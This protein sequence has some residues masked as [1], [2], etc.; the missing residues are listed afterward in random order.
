MSPAD[1]RTREHFAA[2]GSFRGEPGLLY[3]AT[4][5]RDWDIQLED[6]IAA[7]SPHPEIPPTDQIEGW[8][9][10]WL[11]CSRWAGTV[12][13]RPAYIYHAGRAGIG[14]LID[15]ARSRIVEIAESWEWPAID[16]LDALDDDALETAFALFGAASHVS[17]V[18]PDFDTDVDNVEGEQAWK[19]ALTLELKGRG[20]LPRVFTEVS[21]Y[22]GA[23][24][25]VLRPTQLYAD[26]F[27]RTIPRSRLKRIVD[28]WCELFEA[29]PTPIRYLD[30][31][32]RAP[33]RLVAA[34]RGQTQL[35]G[36]E[37]KWGDYGDISPVAGMPDLWNLSLGGASGLTD[38]TALRAATSLRVLALEDCRRL[39]DL[40]PLGDL[41][42]LEELSLT[43]GIGSGSLTVSTIEFL[44]GMT[45][46]RRLIV[47]AR[48][49]DE[50]Y[51]ALL[52][53]AD[54]EE[55]WVRKQRNMNP[56]IDELQDQIPDM[57]LN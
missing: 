54:L 12:G 49:L 24:R 36:L 22:D 4:R 51:S 29:S 1:G 45:G 21:E 57:R 38:V 28:E 16:E 55:L 19:F 40:S 13:R 2:L 34:L 41:D 18:V 8:V 43:S 23:E 33:G 42:I 37:I 31:S 39:T 10:A 25:I 15:A 56:S 27:G 6:W 20:Q 53:R 5:G 14:P 11:Y 3:A 7:A 35:R 47:G 52:A 44:R 32:T 26:E 50:D 9:W 17:G 30:I 48:V 46:L